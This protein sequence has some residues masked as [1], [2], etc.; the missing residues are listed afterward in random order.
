[1]LNEY[2]ATDARASEDFCH[3]IE[4][5]PKENPFNVHYVR[6]G[7]VPTTDSILMYDYGRTFVATSGNP[8]NGNILGELWVSYEVELKK[9]V[10][11]K[12]LNVQSYA[13]TAIAGINSGNPFGTTWQTTKSTMW[14]PVTTTSAGVVTFP[15]GSYGSWQVTYWA[16][17]GA[18]NDLGIPT[19]TGCDAIQ[20]FGP[21]VSKQTKNSALSDA[22]AT[23]TISITGPGVATV[24]FTAATL[25][26]AR[27][28]LLITEINP[29][30]Q[31]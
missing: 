25:T 1:M 22:V 18:T 10:V 31:T 29:A 21:N 19:T 4:C 11:S 20:C 9:P 6:M 5:S 16:S 13:A 24:S 2:W 26:S 14:L 12:T 15:P 8:A 27:V 17:G 3:P 30:I 23:I 7:A 28:G